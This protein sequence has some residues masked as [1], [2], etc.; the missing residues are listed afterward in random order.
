MNKPE[1][2]IP[3]NM[4]LFAKPSSLDSARSGGAD[5]EVFEI[6]EVDVDDVQALKTMQ[7]DSMTMAKLR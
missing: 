2:S 1:S 3:I 4:K 6:K 7:I 5:F